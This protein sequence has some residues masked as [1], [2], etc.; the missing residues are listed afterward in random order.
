MEVSYRSIAKLGSSLSLDVVSSQ[1][2]AYLVLQG[3]QQDK[4]RLR[5]IKRA[6]AIFKEAKAP[7]LDLVSAD[8]DN[9]FPSLLFKYENIGPL[10]QFFEQASP[11]DCYKSGLDTGRA[12]HLLHEVKPPGSLLK[13]AVAPEIRN[14][15]K[16]TGYLG[17][18]YRFHDEKETLDALTSRFKTFQADRLGLRFGNLLLEDLFLTAEGELRML[19]KASFKVGDPAEDL[20]SLCA[21]ASVLSPHFCAGVIDGCFGNR[22]PLRFWLSFAM[23]TALISLCRY[24]SEIERYGISSQKGQIA[25]FKSRQLRADY[26][27]FNKPYPVWYVSD[28]VLQLRARAL[29]KGL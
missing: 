3:T 28:E 24:A 4:R 11:L 14:L 7:L 29:Q 10:Q 2:G 1:S 9:P 16:L 20:A 25:L 15:K 6:S 22:I 13:N 12:L 18:R 8:F 23:Y 27:N 26:A 5:R 19:P 17:S 21:D